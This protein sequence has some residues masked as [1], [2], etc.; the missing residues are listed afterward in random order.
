MNKKLFSVLYLLQRLGLVKVAEDQMLVAT[1]SDDLLAPHASMEVWRK[2][3]NAVIEAFKK[4]IRPDDPDPTR[5]LNVND[6]GHV[7]SGS[8]VRDADFTKMFDDLAATAREINALKSE[9]NGTRQAMD[10]LGRDVSNIKDNYQVRLR[11]VL[12][13]SEPA[14]K[15]AAKSLKKSYPSKPEKYDKMKKKEKESCG[16]NEWT[17]KWINDIVTAAEAG[18]LADDLNLLKVLSNHLTAESAH[19][20]WRIEA[21]RRHPDQGGSSD[22][23]AAF[24]A[25]WDRVEQMFPK[26]E[27]AAGK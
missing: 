24:G 22:T 16:W 5:H 12:E 3:L 13:L 20:S 8:P 11:F 2:D 1:L 15:A 17:E 18:T 23:S 9:E 21:A 25:I 6:I 26:V 27:A 19:A 10:I 14:L 7:V 4:T